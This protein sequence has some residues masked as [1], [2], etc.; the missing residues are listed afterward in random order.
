[1]GSFLENLINVSLQ[2][3]A[4]P[5]L[6]QKSRYYI[7][8]FSSKNDNSDIIEPQSD[9][10]NAKTAIWSLRESEYQVSKSTFCSIPSQIDRTKSNLSHILPDCNSYLNKQAKNKIKTLCLVFS[11]IH[12]T[13]LHNSN[14]SQFTEQTLKR[15]I[16]SLSLKLI[17]S[18]KVNAFVAQRFPTVGDLQ[19]MISDILQRYSV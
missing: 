5:G 4:F 6:F 2:H 1:M 8:R 12:M 14:K 15:S 9:G 18:E 3:P 19:S 16:D 17:K 11:K 13:D 10:S 7:Y